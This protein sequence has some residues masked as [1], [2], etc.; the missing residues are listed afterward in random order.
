M[1]RLISACGV[2]VL[3]CV[4]AF[5]EGWPPPEWQ[6]Y[7]ADLARICPDKHLDL[8]SPADLND[9]I[10]IDYRHR[11]APAVR[12][13]LDR[14]AGRRADGGVRACAGVNGTSCPN[15]AYLRAALAMKRTYDLAVQV[16]SMHEECR[17]QSDRRTISAGEML[18][19]IETSLQKEGAK[20]TLN[21]YFGCE[22]GDG[23]WVVETGDPRAVALAVRLHADSD[24]CVAESL[25]SA[26]GSAMAANPTAVLPYVGSLKQ[27]I[28]LP[29]ISDE[30][31]RS[32]ALA[33]IAR[34]EKAISGVSAPDLIPARD[35][36]LA[37]IRQ[38]RAA[39]IRNLR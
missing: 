29:F 36:C 2:V 5:G 9:V 12:T 32:E 34:S 18:K 39:V 37:S 4:P 17:A 10:E 26:L 14:L 31:S 30:I 6:R 13:E 27:D 19:R 38:A 7:S 24:A 21:R 22:A 1:W 25:V 15:M 8:L 33:I 20:P 3:L 16:C 35:K 28:C 11:L 23:Y